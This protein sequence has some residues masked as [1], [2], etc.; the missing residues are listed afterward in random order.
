VIR[1]QTGTFVYEG[2]VVMVA[3]VP[4]P[5]IAE[6]V[7]TS[8]LAG[9]VIMVLAERPVA[10]TVNCCASDCRPWLA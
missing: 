3:V 6:V 5:E 2:V 1:T 9:A 10:V 7:E 8:K 4:K